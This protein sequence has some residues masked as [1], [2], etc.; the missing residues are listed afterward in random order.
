MYLNHIYVNLQV[1]RSKGKPLWNGKARQASAV[2]ISNNRTLICVI[3]YLCPPMIHPL[4]VK[5]LQVPEEQ[6]R[7]ISR[8]AL[9]R[10]IL[11]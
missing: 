10:K 11:I 6:N 2:S 1:V 3:T 7:E 8:S 9:V 5:H 4:G